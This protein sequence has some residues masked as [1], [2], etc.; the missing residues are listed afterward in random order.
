MKVPQVI[1]VESNKRKWS[2]PFIMFSVKCYI[3][4]LKLKCLF[5]IKAFE[6]FLGNIST[7]I[8][9][10]FI[11]K[12]SYLIYTYIRDI[13]FECVSNAHTAKHKIIIFYYKTV[14]YPTIM[15]QEKY[16]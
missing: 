5:T 7:Q 1:S 10:S 2:N 13:H 16:L 14:Q 3:D 4:K 9:F 15:L 6:W 12:V 8:P 11:K